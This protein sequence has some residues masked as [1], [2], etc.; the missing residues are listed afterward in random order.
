MPEGT[1]KVLCLIVSLVIIAVP[2]S[3]IEAGDL[4]TLYLMPD[5]VTAVPLAGMADLTV[6]VDTFETVVLPLLPVITH[7]YWYVPALAADGV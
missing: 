3:E 2:A 6:T 1:V 4:V 7:L 5:F